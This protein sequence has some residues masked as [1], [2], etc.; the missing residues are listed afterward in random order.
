MGIHKTVETRHGTTLALKIVIRLD[1]RFIIKSC[2]D[3]KRRSRNTVPHPMGKKGKYYSMPFSIQSISNG[4]ND[5]C[6]YI[7]IIKICKKKLD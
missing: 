3:Q 7:S 4:E 2:H 1:A 6:I 5:Y